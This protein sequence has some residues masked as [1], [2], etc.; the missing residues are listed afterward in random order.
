MTLNNKLSEYF[1][2]YDKKFKEEYE[3]GIFSEEIKR[4]IENNEINIFTINNA[5]ERSKFD[6]TTINEALEDICT[7]EKFKVRYI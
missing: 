4:K 7:Y 3:N 5:I 6:G 1:K 2:F